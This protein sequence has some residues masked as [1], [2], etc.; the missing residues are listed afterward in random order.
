MK[1]KQ[2]LQRFIDELQVK[3][4]DS[5]NVHVV[6]A[7]VHRVVSSQKVDIE[8]L[9]AKIMAELDALSQ[10]IHNARQEIAALRPDQVTQ[11]YLPAAANELDAVVEA[12]AEATHAI[13]DATEQIESVVDKVDP[14]VRQILEDAT[15][16]VYEACGFQDL[17][18]Q[19][20]NKVVKTLREIEM[21]VDALVAVFGREVEGGLAAMAAATPKPVTDADLL[22]GPQLD[23]QGISQDDIDRLLAELDGK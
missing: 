23:G 14:E 8:Q 1:D 12:T 18:G 9:S 7:I 4:G 22:S 15:M 5:V 11:E 10:F 6:A 13:M 19:R 3:F 16:K 21:K 17:T 2:N 20:I